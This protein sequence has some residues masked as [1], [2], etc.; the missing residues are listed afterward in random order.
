[1]TTEDE[2]NLITEKLKKFALW[3]S[4]ACVICDD[5]NNPLGVIDIHNYNAKSYRGEIG[6]RIASKHQW[7]GIMTQALIHFMEAIHKTWLCKK[8]VLL[9]QHNNI[10]SNRVAQKA[11]FTFIGTLRQHIMKHGVLEDINLYEKIM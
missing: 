1:L 2:I 4:C 11:W 6:Y 9:A 5:A 10:G 7:K 3:T 8:F